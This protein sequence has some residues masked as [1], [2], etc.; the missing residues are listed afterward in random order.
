MYLRQ[1]EHDSVRK[2]LTNKWR[3]VSDA[4]ASA[5]INHTGAQFPIVSKQNNSVHKKS[6]EKKKY[7]LI[8]TGFDGDDEN[9]RPCLK[10]RDCRRPSRELDIT[11]R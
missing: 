6:T 7:L 11:M 10:D 2:M 8:G 4:R 9:G 3:K 1:E 5:R